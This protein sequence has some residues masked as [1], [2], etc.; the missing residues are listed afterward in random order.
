MEKLF[1]SL[2]INLAIIP[3]RGK[4]SRHRGKIEARMET[5]K[6]QAPMQRGDLEGAGLSSKAS[7]EARSTETQHHG[8]REAVCPER[9][10][11]QKPQQG[12]HTATRESQDFRS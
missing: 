1:K 8:C 9:R 4:P 2:M 12:I 6:G 5:W 10:P 11:N 3:V 7:G